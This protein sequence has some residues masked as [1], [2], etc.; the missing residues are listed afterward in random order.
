MSCVHPVLVGDALLKIFAAGVDDVVG[1]DT[2]RSDVS[3]VSVAGIVAQKL[4]EI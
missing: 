2:L 3:T 4:R 1:T